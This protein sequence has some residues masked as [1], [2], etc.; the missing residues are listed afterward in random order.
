MALPTGRGNWSER[1][2]TFFLEKYEID[3]GDGPIP[4]RDLE[5]INLTRDDIHHSEQEFGMARRM[6]QKHFNR[7]PEG[8]FSDELDLQIHGEWGLY[9]P[10]IYVTTENLVEAIRR[11]EVF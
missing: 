9:P 3:W 10:R 8:L 7:F 5:E 1:Y 6:N 2:R 11:V 4:L